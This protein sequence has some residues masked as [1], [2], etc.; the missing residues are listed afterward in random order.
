MKLLSGI[1]LTMLLLSTSFAQ[2]NETRMSWLADSYL[3]DNLEK[4]G[5]WE[6]EAFDTKIEYLCLKCDGKVAATIEVI[7]PYEA[8]QHVSKQAR[9][10]SERKSYCANLAIKNE[11]RCISTS[12]IGF[13]GGALSGF[14]S[15]HIADGEGKI[16]VVF[17][18]TEGQRDPELI[19]G[20]ITDS[21]AISDPRELLLWHMAKLTLWW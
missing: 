20:T 2:A 9:Y 12:E 10:L 19:K 11:G 18:Y 13:R 7:A 21:G 16:E 15:R 5:T 3:I 4:G 1:A 17:F 8:L 6:V 14:E